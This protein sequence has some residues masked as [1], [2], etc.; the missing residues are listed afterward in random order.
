MSGSAYKN[1][2]TQRLAQRARVLG[3]DP[4]VLLKRL[5]FQRI[6]AASRSMSGGSS[7]AAS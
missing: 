3:L 4:N 6:L 2:V 7:R 1:S 5:A